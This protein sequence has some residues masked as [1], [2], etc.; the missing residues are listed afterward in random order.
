MSSTS[1]P[2][3]R[4]KVQPMCTREA[5]LPDAEAIY[6]L[7]SAYSTDGTLL[8]RTLAEICENVRDFVVLEQDRQIIGCGALHLYG[9]HLAEIRSITVDAGSQNSGGGRLLI[10]ALDRQNNGRT[11]PGRDLFPLL[12]TFRAPAGF[13]FHP[14]CKHPRA[15]VSLRSQSCVRISVCLTKLCRANDLPESRGECARRS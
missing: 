3:Q 8:P 12:H 7:I 14:S 9:P 4:R 5:V 1:V 13:L 15:L 2:R 6:R 11:R 10:D